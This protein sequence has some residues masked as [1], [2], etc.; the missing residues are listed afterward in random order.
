MQHLVTLKLKHSV[1]NLVFQS[2]ILLAPLILFF[3]DH[4]IGRNNHSIDPANVN[5]QEASD[6]INQ[7][8]AIDPNNPDARVR[9]RIMG[10]LF[11]HFFR[12]INTFEGGDGGTLVPAPDP[13]PTSPDIVI[14]GTPS[15]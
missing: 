6:T 5:P 11:S 10:K 4:P 3:Y 8:P 13:D 7:R 12:K 15:Y 1:L 9:A 2:E 14:N